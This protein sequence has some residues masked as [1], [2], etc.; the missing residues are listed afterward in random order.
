MFRLSTKAR[1]TQRS[2]FRSIYNIL[3]VIFSL[4]KRLCDRT[5]FSLLIFS[6]GETSSF[7]NWTPGRH[8]G[9]KSSCL[10]AAGAECGPREVRGHKQPVWGRP[11]VV[12]CQNRGTQTGCQHLV[13]TSHVISHIPPV[14]TMLFLKCVLFPTRTHFPVL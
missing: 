8:F 4:N 10:W 9:S 12:R 13:T 6:N 7:A 1:P 14:G 2:L 3:K 5:L 11:G